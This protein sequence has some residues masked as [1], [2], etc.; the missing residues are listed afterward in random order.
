MTEPTGPGLVRGKPILFV[1]AAGGPTL[2]GP[3]DYLTPIVN[4]VFGFIGFSDIK[5]V[6]VNES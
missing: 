3:T 1:S 2:G 5:H 4:S 6:Y